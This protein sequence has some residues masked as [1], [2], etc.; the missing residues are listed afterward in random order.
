MRHPIYAAFLAML[1]ATGLLTSAGLILVAATV[2][3]MA[4]SEFRIG[5]EEAKLAE[6]FPA[7]YAQYRLQTRWLY[8]PGLR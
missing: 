4:G 6:N 7:S 2:L 1:L 5:S 3:Y 8:L